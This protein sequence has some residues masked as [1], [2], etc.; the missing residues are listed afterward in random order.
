MIIFDF[1][2]V[3]IDS[4]NE[5]A[6]TTYNAATENLFTSLSEIPDAPIALFKR[7]RFHVQQIGDAITLMNWCIDRHQFKSTG[8]L[9][10]EKYR[11][12]AS[13]DPATLNDRTNLIYETRKRFIDR[14]EKRW[15]SLHQPYQP[16]WNELIKGDNHVF[17]ILTNKNHDATLRL[18]RHFGLDIDSNDIYSGDHGTTKVEN[19]Q[20]IQ[21]RFGIEFVSFIDD[22]VKNL[23][24]LD[25]EFNQ[26]KKMLSLLLADWGYTGPADARI[27]QELGYPVFN[28]TDLILLMQSIA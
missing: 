10:K 17:V 14:D 23:K 9:S 19:M 2:G 27:A 11:T 12:I 7:N 15:L 25:F 21:T 6:L 22:S 4:L 16:L 3:L 13:G 1:D 18:C 8:T 5:V 20:Q 26:E 24:E 28:Q